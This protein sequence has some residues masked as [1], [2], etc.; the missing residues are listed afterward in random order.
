MSY[1]SF[2]KLNS[3]E[4]GNNGIRIMTCSYNDIIKILNSIFFK[5]QISISNLK[6]R[7]LL[8]VFDVSSS[9]IKFYIFFK[10]LSLKS[11]HKVSFKYLS[12][13]VS[14]DWLSKMIFKCIV[15]KLEALFGKIGPELT[16]HT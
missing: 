9:A 16:I 6:F 3:F 14:R 13:Q 11:F 12:W 4:S 5:L 7:N 10:S 8:N 15:R 1:F 2:K